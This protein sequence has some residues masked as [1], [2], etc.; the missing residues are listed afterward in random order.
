VQLTVEHAHLA[1]ALVTVARSVPARTTMPVLGGILVEASA[2]Q[3]QLAATDLEVTSRLRVPAAVAAPGRVVVPARLLAE[4]V[5][6]IPGGQIAWESDPERADT[7]LRWQRSEF[8]LHGFRADEFPALP[9]PPDDAPRTPFDFATLRETLRHTVFAAADESGGRPILTGVALTL[10]DGAYRA[11]ATDGMRVAYYRTRAE[12]GDWT[13]GQTFTLPQ[14]GVA[15]IVRCLEGEG[16]GSFCAAGSHLHVAA[17][18]VRLAVRL[19][20]GSYPAILELLPKQFPTV[21]R[22]DLASLRDACERVAL[23]TDAPDRLH[24]VSLHLRAGEIEV[25]AR[26][27]EVGEAREVIPADV[28]GPEL[29]FGANARLLLEGLRHLPDGE[30]VA[31]FSGPLSLARFRSLADPRLHYMHM[32]LRMS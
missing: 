16:E 23:V 3:L 30:A 10:L 2:H 29:D 11:L 24:A 12:R 7:V 32:P 26:S 15:E 8:H 17:G 21:A 27:P 1:P 13:D 31:E 18:E 25:S 9:E 20:E 6:R 28:D 14:R 4:I 22:V 5:R 19:L